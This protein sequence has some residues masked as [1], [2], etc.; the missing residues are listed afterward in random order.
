VK[1]VENWLK[2]TLR[3]SG[4]SLSLALGASSEDARELEER[5][6]RLTVNDI[7]AL[8]RAMPEEHARRMLDRLM[9]VF[10]L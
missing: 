3:E 1:K 7:G 8:C 9:G 2:E 6:G 10:A 4:V 5:P